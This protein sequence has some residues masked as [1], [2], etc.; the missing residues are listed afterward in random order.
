M[1][2]VPIESFGKLFLEH[3]QIELEI[4]AEAAGVEICRTNQRPDVIHQEQLGMGERRRLVEY[5][6]AVGQKFP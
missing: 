2:E 3:A 6:D 4:E 1:F 5:P